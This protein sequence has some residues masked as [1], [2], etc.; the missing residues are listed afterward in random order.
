MDTIE[1]IT[2][3]QHKVYLKPQLNHGDKRDVQRVF[4]AATTVDPKTEETSFDSSAIYDAQDLAMRR[5]LQRMVLADG[6]VVEGGEQC[7]TTILS[8]EDEQDAKAIYDKV[9]AL[10]KANQLSTEQ[11]KT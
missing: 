3:S 2:P 11:K 8:W 7:L 1:F 4:A 10:T 9:E 5:L 6:T